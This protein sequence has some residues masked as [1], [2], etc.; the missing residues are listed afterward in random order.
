MDS[1]NNIKIS[2][3][4]PVYNVGQYIGRCIESL[5]S[6]TLQ[7]L[8]FIFVDDCGTDQSMKLVEEF[9]AVD[10]RVRIIRNEHNIGAGPSR[11]IGI[12]EAQGEYLSFI[13]P[14]DYISHDF[15]S[16]LYDAAK[17][18]DYDIAKG[19]RVDVDEQTG[20]IR[21]EK[22]LNNNI[23]KGLR[24]HTPLY[25]FVFGHCSAIYRKRLFDDGEVRY[26]THRHSQDMVYL[27]RVSLK[28]SS[29]TF[30]DDAKY[31]YVHREGS[32]SETLTS[33]R[34]FADLGSLE[35]IIE[36]KER[37]LVEDQFVASYL[38][39]RIAYRMNRFYVVAKE[40]EAID[41]LED[42]YIKKL[43]AILSK[44]SNLAIL[45]KHMPEVSVLM[46]YSYLI[47]TGGEGSSLDRLKLWTTLFLLHPSAAKEF[48]CR[49]S[50]VICKTLLGHMPPTSENVGSRNRV[51]SV[52][53]QLGS[54][55]AKTR[56]MVLCSLPRSFLALVWRRL[57]SR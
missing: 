3:V 43:Q 34:L 25:A 16:L 20:E 33:G 18:N 24:C 21:E 41:A 35:E 38:G 15:Y 50:E 5:G 9:A 37:L 46:N 30:A 23:R 12:E 55:D 29:I 40:D 11:N 10:R 31:Y 27:F 19:I 45:S 7:D 39:N 8:E 42:N 2:A 57:R 1:V 51:L 22:N 32:A 56:S 14:D 4:I 44:L 17:K 54:L 52:W 53:R 26:G 13:D 36:T 28:A 48:R 47:P 6:Q 49:Y